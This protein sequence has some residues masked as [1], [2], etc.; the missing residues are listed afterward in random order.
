[1][2]NISVVEVLQRKQDL[3]DYQRGWLLVKG[4]T[5]V[6]NEGEKVTTCDKFGEHVPSM[7]VVRT[8][9]RSL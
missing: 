7:G 4:A 5:I 2:Y 1:M 3:S 6:S 9:S 8:M